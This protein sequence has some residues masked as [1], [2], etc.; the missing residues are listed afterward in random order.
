[1][2]GQSSIPTAS[3]KDTMAVVAEVVA[4]TLGKGVLARRP[5]MVAAAERFSLNERAIRRLQKL[6]RAYG[7][8]PLRLAVPIRP[9]TVILSPGH[10]RRVL[11]G[12]PDPFSPAT[13]E[14]KAALA[15]FEPLVSLVS[16]PPER[17]ERRAFNEDLLES[18]VRTHSM[19]ATAA[20]AVETEARRLTQDAGGTV[21]WEA[22][23][24]AWHAAVRRFVLG[25]AAVDDRWLTE[26]LARLRFDGNWAFLKPRRRQLLIRF[27][28]RLDGHLARAEPDSL[29]ARI[30]ARRNRAETAIIDQVTHWLFAYD[31]AGIAAWRALA[32]IAA[33]PEAR[34]RARDEAMA[35]GAELPFI[36]ACILESLRL[37]PTAP[38]ILRETTDEVSWESGIMP[39][40]SQILIYT[41]FFHRDDETMPFAHRFAPELWLEG[42]FGDWPLVPF[43]DG[44]GI[45]PARDL[46]PMMTAMMLAAILRA[47]DATLA[48]PERLNPERPMPGTLDN[49]TLSFRLG[50]ADRWRAA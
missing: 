45:C 39:K 37:W 46:V 3:I 24:D 47:G 5:W 10:L 27:Q 16:R 44:P 4:P 43:S 32:L 48:E 42:R 50:G 40:G 13:R 25:P 35:G 1:M 11:A 21:G 2:A 22:F 7:E 9:Q 38:A 29:S 18:G 17:A 26:L 34:R 31:P 28:D 36:R 12:A 23:S 6:R 8:G 19:A 30:A 15:H 49:F 20:T 41:P 14:K 33:H